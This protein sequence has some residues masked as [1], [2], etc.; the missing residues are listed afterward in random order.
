MCDHEPI[1]RRD[2][3]LWYFQTNSL[4]V[5]SLMMPLT[6]L[7]PTTDV[8]AS[9]EVAKNKINSPGLE[10]DEPEAATGPRQEGG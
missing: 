10:V 8:N 4:Q 7:T 3:H 9:Q 6:N 2:H 5:Y 1:K